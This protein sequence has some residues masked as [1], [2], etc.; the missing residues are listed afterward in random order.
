[1]FG[2]G[3]VKSQ[4]RMQ[5]FLRPRASCERR[6][7]GRLPQTLSDG[8]LR[9]GQRLGLLDRQRTDEAVLGKVD[10]QTSPAVIQ[11]DAH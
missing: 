4:M 9:L 2:T 11:L 8:F 7:A 3:R 10:V 5:A 1:L 6:G